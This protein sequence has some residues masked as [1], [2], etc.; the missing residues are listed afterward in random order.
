MHEGSLGYFNSVEEL[1]K[2]TEQY[3]IVRTF[4]GLEKREI[5]AFSRN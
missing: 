5:F 3:F 2:I 1:T 4:C